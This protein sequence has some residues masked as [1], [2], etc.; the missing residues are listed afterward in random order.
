[1]L[2]RKP[3]RME[4]DFDKYNDTFNKVIESIEFIKE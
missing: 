2:K 1:M 3:V 4:Y